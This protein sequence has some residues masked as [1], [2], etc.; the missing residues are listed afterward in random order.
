MENLLQDV[1]VND[2]SM[3]NSYHQNAVNSELGVQALLLEGED[4]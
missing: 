3:M 2:P 1:Q 4:L